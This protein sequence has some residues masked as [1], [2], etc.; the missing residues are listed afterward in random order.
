MPNPSPAW[1]Y[2]QFIAHRGAGRYAPEN[3]LAAMRLGAQHGFLMMEY[4]VKLS[5]DGVAILLHDDAVD[6]TSNG[7]GNA[8][9][10]T[11][12]ELAQIDF[13]AWHS[14]D[15]AGEPIPTLYSIAAYT[16]A[17]GIR[18]NIEIKPHTG[19]EAET[20]RQV[21]R[22]ARRLW[23]GADLPPLLSSFSETALEAALN[24]APELPR[25][26]LIEEEVP[27]DWRDR[28]QR[29][30]CVGLNLNHKHTTRAIVQAV[31]QAGYTLAIWTVNDAARARELLDWGCDAIVT[32]EIKT[33]SP[34]WLA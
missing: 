25:A 17:N 1:P 7:L 12:A 11:L 5:R 32:D 33:I 6:R 10:K 8:A 19:L 2:P 27:A 3:T 29:L 24:E 34:A 26:L 18:S 31:R 14:R 4:D 16:R 22:L 13:G 9:D 20:G 21:A 30:Q 15:Y 28:A 23:A